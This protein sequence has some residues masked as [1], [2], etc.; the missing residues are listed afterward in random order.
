MNF[1]IRQLTPDEAHDAAPALGLVLADCVAGGASVSFMAGLTP[2]RA[3]A[4][5]RKE[6]E[7]AR[8]D[9][10]AIIVAEDDSGVIGVV[11]MIPAWPE[12]QPHRADVAKMLVHRRARRKG[13]AAAL[14]HAA[15]DAARRMRKT[16]LTLDTFTGTDADRLYARLGWTRAGAIPD[17]ALGP[18]GKLAETTLFYKRITPP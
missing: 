1:R 11:Q 15:E 17:Y 6:A 10:R 3:A 5:W 13:V 16:L 14:L 12:N 4:F 7:D 18:D 8:S 2:E 9:G